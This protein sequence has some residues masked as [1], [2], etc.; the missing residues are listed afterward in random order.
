[1]VPWSTRNVEWLTKSPPGM[2]PRSWQLEKYTAP[3]VQMSSFSPIRGRKK[4]YL[5][6]ILFLV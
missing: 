2:R 6:S 4:I 5:M 3:I 1:M